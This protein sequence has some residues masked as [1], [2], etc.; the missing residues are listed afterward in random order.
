MPLVMMVI[1]SL[2]VSARQER[3]DGQRSFGLAHKDAGGHVQHSAPQVPM[4]RVISH[5]VP[6]MMICITPM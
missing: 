1:N 5:A 4:M 2:R 6:R 3:P